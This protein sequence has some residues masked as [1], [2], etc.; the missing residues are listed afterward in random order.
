[1][2]HPAPIALCLALSLSGCALS[3]R[4]EQSEPDAG[5]DEPRGRGSEACQRWQQSFCDFAADECGLIDSERCDDQNRG[6][7]C[8][9]DEEATRCA[10]GFA[11]AACNRPPGGCEVADIAD[12]RAAAEACETYFEAQCESNTR[13]G[14]FSNIDDCLESPL[15]DFDCDRAL[16]IGLD[17]E[18]CLQ[19]LS[20]RRCD[21]DV[22]ICDEVIRA[23]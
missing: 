11:V 12:R 9:D 1:M 3:G 16:S 15:F 21:R 7:V 8:A 17:F 18:Q 4:S 2:T 13:C 23:R 5:S 14:I 20:T 6:V 22:P 19:E 10:D